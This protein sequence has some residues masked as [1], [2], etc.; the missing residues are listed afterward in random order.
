V[1]KVSYSEL[2]YDVVCWMGVCMAVVGIRRANIWVTV[3]RLCLI[4]GCAWGSNCIGGI[5]HEWT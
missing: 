4:G 1:T 5:N 2:K 3:A